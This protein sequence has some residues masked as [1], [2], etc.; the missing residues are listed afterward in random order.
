MSKAQTIDVLK[1]AL[2]KAEA[3]EFLAVGVVGVKQ[4]GTWDRFSDDEKQ[5]SLIGGLHCLAY[6]IHDHA[7]KQADKAA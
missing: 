2:A 1:D 3:G 4:D 7:D 6:R 5:T